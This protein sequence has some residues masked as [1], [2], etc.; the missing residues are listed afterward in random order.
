M[1]KYANRV[2]VH[3][4]ECAHVGRSVCHNVIRFLSAHTMT[5]AQE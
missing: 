5:T 3:E 2:A 4:Y 1:A